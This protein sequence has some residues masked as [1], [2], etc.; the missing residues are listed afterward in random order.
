VDGTGQS[1]AGAAMIA[2]FLLVLVV[3]SVR[4]SVHFG[5]MLRLRLD[6]ARRTRELDAAKAQL[7]AEMAEHRA[8][9]ESLRHAQKMEAVGQLA[10]GIAHDFNNILQAVSGG[11]ALIRRRARDPAI[12]R[13]AGMVADAARRGES[14]TRRLLAFA[15]RGE[16]RAEVLDLGEVLGGLR[17]V[18]AATLHPG[19]RV[20]VEATEGLPPVLADRGQLE[21]ALVNLAVNARDAMP[22]GGT[23]TLSASVAHFRAFD[24]G[25]RLP[26]G[27]YVCLA[28]SDTGTGMDAETLARAC[29]P[30]FTT[31]PRGQGTGLG[32][33]MAR[34]F[35]EGS[36]GALAIDSAPGSGTRV[37]IWLPIAGD[38]ARPA[39]L[40][41][42]R[43]RAQRGASGSR[44]ARRADVLLVDDEPAVRAVLAQELAEEGFNVID[45]A[46][47]AAA[48]ALL[49]RPV[50]VDLLVSDLAMPGIDGIALIREA[51]RR[52]PGLP[53]ILLTGYAGEAAAM[54]VDGGL[55]QDGTLVLLRKPVTGA[56][57]AD[58]VAA[59]LDSA[60]PPPG[61]VAG[62]ALRSALP[63]G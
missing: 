44:A 54:A 53:A 19:V 46:D 24:G 61:P 11:A 52:C 62:A 39:T 35:A 30:F 18:L 42:A 56:V 31:K 29:E 23:L 47:G 12:E 50:P 45:A 25:T 27:A 59:L 33:A 21:T 48:L 37:S 13:L 40:R 2:I 14:V 22:E 38:A 4:S 1:L 6:L 15:R 32:L 7:L 5:E 63:P 20:E 49:D 36:G 26:P 57:L 8:T 16:L 28:V 34:S 58:H 43:D 10:G 9:E 3:S 51:R 41:P 17:E 55:D 60:G